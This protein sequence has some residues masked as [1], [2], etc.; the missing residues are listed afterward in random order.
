MRYMGYGIPDKPSSEYS[1]MEA[2]RLLDTASTY[3][4]KADRFIYSYGSRTFLFGYDLYDA[5]HGGKGNI[6]CSTLMFLVIASIPYDRSPYA[7][8]S[9]EELR[10][11][12]LPDEL[13]DLL[14][15]ES[16]PDRYMEISERIGRP[17][18][19]GEKGLDLEKAAEMGISLKTLRDEIQ[20]SGKRRMSVS[21]A[22]HYLALNKCFLSSGDVRPG[23][24]VF[25]ISPNFFIE[26]DDMF[27][28]EPQVVHVGIVSED[29]SLM[30]N[31]SGTRFKDKLDS[32]ELPGISLSPVT[33]A[34]APAFFA[35]PY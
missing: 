9:I 25:Y 8:G 27:Q 29:T 23:D 15:T 31:S 1:Q 33:G 13:V 34:R 6:D 7:A 21:I 3:L 22:E 26:D 30:I 20:A 16:I 35:R 24:I 32:E 11:M 17:Y 19:K 4:E 28:R 5:E 2:L 10:H 14:D 18:L 12:K